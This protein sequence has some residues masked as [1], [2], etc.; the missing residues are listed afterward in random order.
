MPGLQLGEPVHRRRLVGQ[1]ARTGRVTL[2]DLHARWTPGS[3]DF[4]ALTRAADLN[5][6]ALNQPVV[7]NPTLIPAAFDG[8]YACTACGEGLATATCALPFV[9]WERFNTAVRHARRR[10]LYACRREG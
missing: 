10:F 4:A 3:W 5:T 7:G 8:A 2:W 6:A 1:G 9:R